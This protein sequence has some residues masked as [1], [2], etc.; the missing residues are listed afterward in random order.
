MAFFPL[1][2]RC[3]GG[4]LVVEITRTA[5]RREGH[6]LAYYLL[7]GNRLLKRSGRS[8]SNLQICAAL[9]LIGIGGWILPSP[10]EHSI[11]TLDTPLDEACSIRLATVSRSLME[12]LAPGNV[13]HAMS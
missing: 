12:G 2:S 7:I 1:R 13:T 4:Y 11:P 9:S 6:F 3:I 8:T 5:I 10:F